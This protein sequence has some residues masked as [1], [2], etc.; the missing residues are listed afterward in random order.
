[1][2][3]EIQF[4]ISEAAKD[5]GIPVICSIINNLNNDVPSDQIDKL[6]EQC[7]GKLKLELTPDFITADPVLAGFRNLHQKVGRSN[8]RF[9]SSPESLVSL[10][11][12]KGIIPKINPIVDLYNIVSL[13]S[14]LALGAHDLASIDGN[15]TLKLTDGTERFMPLGAVQPEPIAQGE[16]SYVDDSNEIICRLEHKQV[17][18]TKVTKTTKAAFFIIQGNEATDSKFVQATFQRMAGLLEEHCSGRVFKV[19]DYTASKSEYF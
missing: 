14:R 9:P 17:E 3:K 7:I 15:V 1:M 6:R 19:W 12:V 5:L 10:F 13:E 4:S 11:L 18:K 8:R 16:Y 2:S